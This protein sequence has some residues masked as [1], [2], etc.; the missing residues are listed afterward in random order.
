MP[1]TTGHMA[2][3]RRRNGGFRHRY[4]ESLDHVL[5]ELEGEAAEPAYGSRAAGTRRAAGALR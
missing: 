5:E 2:V 1:E 3:K 4:D